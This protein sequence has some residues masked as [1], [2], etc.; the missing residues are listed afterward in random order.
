ML[1]S[2][3]SQT[4]IEVSVKRSASIF[5]VL[6]LTMMMKTLRPFESSAATRSAKQRYIT[7][8]LNEKNSSLGKRRILNKAALERKRLL[9]YW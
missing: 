1:F 8:E 3:D 5:R 9:R 2:V 6:T 7:Q 4:V